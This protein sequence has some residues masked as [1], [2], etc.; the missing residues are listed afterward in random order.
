MTGQETTPKIACRCV[1]WGIPEGGADTQQ[2]VF[3]WNLERAALGDIPKSQ[4]FWVYMDSSSRQ[5]SRLK[6]KNK[7]DYYHQAYE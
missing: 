2:V 5:F 3:V 1:V 7:T 4:P 6:K